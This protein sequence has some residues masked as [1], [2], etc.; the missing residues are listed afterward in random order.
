MK[1]SVIIPVYNEEKTVKQTI[2]EIQKVNLDKEIIVV[3]DKS[4]DLTYHIVEEMKYS[5]IVLVKQKVHRGKGAAIREALRYVTGEIVIIQDADLEYDPADYPKLIAPILKNQAEVVYGSRFKGKIKG[6]RFSNLMA[7][8]ILTGVSNMLFG[9][10]ITD[11]ATCYKVFRA[12]V[13]KK[14]PLKC[15]G[16]E[17]CPEITAKIAKRK[18][19]IIEVPISYRARTIAE[20]KKVKWIDGFIAVYTL[21]KYR[22]MD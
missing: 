1:I 19:R 22:F 8:K 20:G 17:F 13:I 16:F 2:S 12:E 7:N 9:I 5:N 18:I 11:E 15:S 3:D 14:I 6:M 21:I 10:H 4:E